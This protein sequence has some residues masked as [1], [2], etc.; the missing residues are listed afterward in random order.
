MRRFKITLAL[1]GAVVASTA[2]GC[3]EAETPV[4]RVGVNVVQKSIF[5]GSWY[6]NRTVIDVDYEAAGIGTYPGD[7]A[8]DFGDSSFAAI[9]RIRWVIDEDFVYAYRD[10]ELLEG[11]NET[12]NRDP[13]APGEYLGHPVAAYRVESHF[14]IKRNYNPVT[15]EESNVIGENSEDRRWY[16]RDYMR[17][18][19]SKNVLPAYYG[20]IHNLYE[21]L[22]LYKREPTDL[23]VQGA[24]DFPDSWQPRFDYMSCAGSDDMNCPEWERDFADDYDQGELYHMSF[25]NQELLSPGDVQDPFTG[26]NVNWC[27]S[28]YSDAPTCT[29]HAVYVRT[30]FLKVSEQRQYDPTQ[31][32]DTRFDRHGYFRLERETYDRS[33]DPTDPAYFRTDFLNYNINRHN[34]WKQWT[35]ADGNAVPYGDRDVRQIVWYTTPELPAHLVKPSLD[36]VG[37]WNAV[38][39]STVRNLRDQPDA[40]YPRVDCQ[41]EN[42]ENY[43]FCQRDPDDPAVILNPS[44]P[45]QYDPFQTPDEATAAGASNPY[46]CWLELADDAEPDMTNDAVAARLTDADFNGWFGVQIR[47][48]ECVTV[49]RMNS[50]NRATI[51][52]NGGT[53]DGLE[54]QE[55]GDARFKYLSYVDQPGTGFLGIATLR[56]DP[57][58]GEI[59]VGD[60]NIGGPALDGYRTSA[61]EQYDLI[62]GNLTDRE[63]WTGENVRKYLESVNQVDMPAPPRID[64]NV[65]LAAGDEAYANRDRQGIDNRMAQVMQRAEQLTGP[66][67]RANIYSHRREALVGTETERRMTENIETLMMAGIDWLPE[68]V[69]PEDINDTILDRASPF[70]TNAHDRLAQFEV[71]E[72]KYA[73]ANMML[74]NEYI[75]N[76]VAHFVEQHAAWPR[77]RLEFELNRSLFY[78]TELHEMG[79]C[80]GLRH[81]FGGSS[82]TQNYFDDYYY[83]N[84]RIPLPEPAAFDLD[85]VAGL[86][87]DEQ[88][89][90]EDAY[91]AARERRELS[92]IDQWMNSSTMEY[93]ANW[94]E[95]TVSTTGRYDYAA[96]AFGYGDIVEAYDNSAG[97]A[98]KDINPTNTARIRL[99]Y[100]NGGEICSTDADCMYSASG[101]RSGELMTG[102]MDAG[103][104]QRCVTSPTVGGANIC[105]NF[106][107]DMLAAADVSNPDG[108]PRYAPVGYRFC[109]DERAAGLSTSTGSI[110]W[111]NRFD[112]GDSYREIVRN[113]A[114][115]YQRMYLFTNFR[116]YRAGFSMGGYLFDRLIGRR[117]IILQNLFENLL[118]EYSSD[119]A[120]R[121]ETGPF[122]FYDQFMASADVLNFYG[123]VMGL[124]DVGTYRWNTGWQ[125]Y[126]RAT[127]DPDAPGAQLAVPVGMGRYGSSVYQRGLSGINRIERIGTFYDKWFTMQLL[128]TRGGNTYTKDIPMFV[129]YYDL[130][131]L[132]MQQM[133]TGLIRGTPEEYMPRVECGAGTFPTC[134]EPRLRYMDFYRG[135]CFSADSETCR[136]DPVQ[137]TY[138]DLP[139]MN[140]ANQFTLQF[141]ATVFA[142][143]EFP[144]FFDTTFQNQLFICVEGQSDCFDP[145]PTDAEG[146]D[147]VRHTSPRFGRSFLAWQVEPTGA[148]TNQTSIGFAMV[149]EARDLEFTLRML[150]KYR[151]DAGVGTP[152]SIENLTT[153]EQEGLVAIDYTLPT[154]PARVNEEIDR[155]DGRLQS[156]ESFFNQVIQLEREMGIAGYLRF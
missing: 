109:T 54:C 153:E 96:I 15:G 23:Y 1:L 21:V 14:D 95:R 22:G 103:L 78:E 74:P 108:T 77:A 5:T 83:I 39:M 104:T 51:A 35:D 151:D 135:D 146:V 127:R 7:S 131:P 34:I 64:F 137:T 41:N 59:I 30:S 102:N 80:M 106:D 18:D 120:F 43:C 119:P 139:V 128:T 44:C 94:Y 9:P 45:G 11:A 66:E 47:G 85:D 40:S 12:A 90:F 145:D 116:R 6:I 140:G 71:M 115:S 67:G 150:Q 122:G 136:P 86:N 27:L 33:T 58:S 143:S 156:L 147:Y 152:F 17:V 81:D 57:V 13:A 28:I 38:F 32:S 154:D 82:D 89:A 25:V 133:F 70:R 56:G 75:D 91:N 142:L 29:S 155:V 61:L 36:L 87:S 141:L 144:V 130:F 65:A 121:N 50:C 98:L 55:R 113:V 126:Q 114:D 125:R 110:G 123:M 8:M 42:P 2:F 3:G 24:S 63:F 148:V 118:H 88:R 60:A 68:G 20:Q 84:D 100:Y 19:W 10:Y 99:K 138:R 69:G 62:N 46:D 31:W 79:H 92:G 129:N 101:A 53:A 112:E 134:A 37:A 16:E 52:D 26:G 124:P 107:E 105:S 93:T 49:L 132:E 4:N 76:S 72:Q 73:R 149:K 97:T 117:F 48:E 111:C